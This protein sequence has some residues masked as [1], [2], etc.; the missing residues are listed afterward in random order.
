MV[1]TIVLL[2][3]VV[4]AR[5]RTGLLTPAVVVVLAQLRNK[6]MVNFAPNFL[7]IT[8]YRRQ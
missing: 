5:Y 6:L 7:N 4:V 3:V 1:G 2:I 8:I